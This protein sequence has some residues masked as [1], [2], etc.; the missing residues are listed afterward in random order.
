MA[1]A[2]LNLPNLPISVARLP[3]TVWRAGHLLPGRRLVP[4]ETAIPFT[5]NGSSRAVMWRRRRTSRIS[6]P[7]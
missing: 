6:R 5:Y 4:E 7:G 2:E 1:F 3:R